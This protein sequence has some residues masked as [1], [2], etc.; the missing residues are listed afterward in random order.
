MPP[1]RQATNLTQEFNLVWDEINK[2]KEVQSGRV[3][4]N[5]YYFKE[6]SGGELVI[7]NRD[8]GAQTIV[9]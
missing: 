2:L 7:V 1:R 9:A 8:T 4:P 5:G 6:L 3:L